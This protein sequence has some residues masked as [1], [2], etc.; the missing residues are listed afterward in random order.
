MD[1]ASDERCD[2]T[3]DE[4]YKR[5]RKIIGRKLLIVFLAIVALIFL[6]ELDV[7]SLFVCFSFGFL[8]V[9]YEGVTLFLLFVAVYGVESGDSDI[10]NDINAKEEV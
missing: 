6:R 9:L 7:I 1:R 5:L 10:L 3:K 4:F 2:V 8:F